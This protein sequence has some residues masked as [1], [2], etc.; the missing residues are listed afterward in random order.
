MDV[1]KIIENFRRSKAQL[2]QDLEY[3]SFM[4]EV[5]EGYNEAREEKQETIKNP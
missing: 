3:C 1:R 2:V 4:L 5:I